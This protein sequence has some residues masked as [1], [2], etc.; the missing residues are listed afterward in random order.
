MRQ[1]M[2]RRALAEAL[3]LAAAGFLGLGALSLPTATAEDYKPLVTAAVCNYEKLVRDISCLSDPRLIAVAAEILGRLLGTPVDPATL[4]PL[5]LD[6]HRPAGLMVETD[7]QTFPMYGFLPVTDLSRLLAGSVAA[8]RLKAPVDGVYQIKAADR[9]WF[10]AQKGGWAMFA[11]ARANLEKT[12]GDPVA[13]L[14]GLHKSYDLGAR[15]LLKNLPEEVRRAGSRWLREGHQLIPERTRGESDLQ[16]ALRTALI[17]QGLQ[18]AASLAD[19]GESVVAGASMDLHARTLTVDLEV[20]AKPGSSIAESLRAPHKSESSFRGFLAPQASL[21][22][23]W[24]GEIARMP[25]YRLMGLLDAIGAKLGLD[26][27]DP[28]IGKLWSTI[29]DSLVEESVDGGVAVV[30]RPNGVTLMAGGSVADGL[31]VQ[32]DLEALAKATGSQHAGAAGCVWR[33][34]AGRYQ[35]VRIHTV[36]FAIPQGVKDRQTLAEWFGSTFEM[37]IGIGKQSVYVAAGRNP[38]EALKNVIRSSQGSVSRRQP[39]VAFTATLAPLVKL[40]AVSGAQEER[41][42][43]VRAAAVLE[44]WPGK[45]HLRLTAWPVPRGT[46]ARL[47]IEEGVL[48]ALAALTRPE[49][50]GPPPRPVPPQPAPVKR[51]KAGARKTD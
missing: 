1:A 40:W 29:R 51:K 10:V 27:S 45:D 46:H 4:A 28:V 39:P 8:G 5:G 16:Y 6:A 35:N 3:G 11:T 24:T 37:A 38:S 15:L 50:A 19:E 36:A 41:S 31:K 34:D 47:E 12:P 21:C 49:S 18:L 7:G 32:R 48:R 42:E 30:V 43:T 9:N 26:A 17:N 25:L 23:V 33:F 2:L 14:E 44:Q 13:A 20:T 22:G